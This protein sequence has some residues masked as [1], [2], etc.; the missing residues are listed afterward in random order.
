MEILI[1]F[2]NS[3]NGYCHLVADSIDNLHFFAQSIGLKRCWFE[4]KKGKK[5]PHYDVKGEMIQKAINAGAKQVSSKEIIIFLNK[6]YK[7]E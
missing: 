6:Y 3:K 2:P 7:N 5:R 1:D 4:N